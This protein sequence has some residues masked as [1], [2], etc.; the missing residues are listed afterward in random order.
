MYGKVQAYL[1]NKISDI[2]SAG[3]YKRERILAGR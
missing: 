1:Q 3:L 2:E